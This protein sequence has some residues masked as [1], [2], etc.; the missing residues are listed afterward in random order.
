MIEVRRWA[1][2]LVTLCAVVS[3]GVV[4][5]HE[6]DEAPY[7]NSWSAAQISSGP[8]H[9]KWDG[10]VPTW[11]KAPMNDVLQSSYA[12]PDFNNS[13]SIRFAYGSGGSATVLYKKRYDTGVPSD[14]SAVNWEGCENGAGSWSWNIW[15]RDGSYVWCQDPGSSG[16]CRDVERVAIHE[17]GH[18]SG[19]LA[20]STE[21]ID[22]TVMSAAA[23]PLSGANGGNDHTLLACD[24]ARMQMLYDL[25]DLSGPYADCF[26]HVPNAGA[27]GLDTVITATPNSVDVCVGTAATI[28]GRLDIFDGHYGRRTGTSPNYAWKLDSNALAGRTVSIKRNGA[29]YTTA[30]ASSLGG[31]NWSKAFTS[32]TYGSFAFTAQFVRSTVDPPPPL[33]AGLDSSNT[34]SFSITWLPP[35]LC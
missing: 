27:K 12:D 33:L 34:A 8:S 21:G 22:D 25:K 6:P 18:A 7:S 29:S 5:A 11:L 16:S 17:A 2:F 35:S 4:V 13:D 26:D 32:G 19:F 1:A 20:H 24:E 14:C 23:S 28:A 31:N 15:I 10:S 9:Y 30:I 3:P